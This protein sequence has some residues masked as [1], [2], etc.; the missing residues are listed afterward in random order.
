MEVE[1]WMISLIIAI[2]GV[3]ATYAVLRNRVSRLETDLAQNEV[4]DADAYKEFNRK[5]DGGFKKLDT[6]IERV[7]ILERDTSTHLTLPRAEERFVTKVEL[8]LHL[9]NI[10]TSLKHMDKSSEKMAGKLEELVDLVHTNVVN[11]LSGK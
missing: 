11:T 2:V 4:N 7:T 5:I 9:R 3:V 8:E 1:S 10:E 6:V